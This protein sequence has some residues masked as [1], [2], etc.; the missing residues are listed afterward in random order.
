VRLDP[1]LAEDG[2]DLVERTL[3]EE[4]AAER[5]LLFGDLLK[6]AGRGAE[7]AAAYSRAAQA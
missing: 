2:I 4:P 7:A 5:L 6:A 1:R 3:G